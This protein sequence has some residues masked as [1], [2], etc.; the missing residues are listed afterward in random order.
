[1]GV[2]SIGV[3]IDAGYEASN[4][5]GWCGHDVHG[6]SE[7]V[8]HGGSTYPELQTDKTLMGLLP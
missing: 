2:R 4:V 5:Y 1:M 8:G 7:A 3:R 6:L